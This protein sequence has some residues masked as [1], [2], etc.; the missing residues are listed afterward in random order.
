MH[1][2]QDTQVK[3]EQYKIYFTHKEGQVYTDIGMSLPGNSLDVGDESE[4]TILYNFF[5]FLI[6]KSPDL[7]FNV[8]RGKID[9][10]EKY[11][12]KYFLAM[13]G[14]NKELVQ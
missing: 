7:V 12:L 10:I 3:S 8:P 4:A 9:V 13:N 1:R 11:K 6:S 14:P 2:L 5:V